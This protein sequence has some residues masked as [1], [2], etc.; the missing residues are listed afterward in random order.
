MNFESRIMCGFGEIHSEIGKKYKKKKERK[1]AEKC[2]Q[3]GQDWA[4]IVSDGFTDSNFT[5]DRGREPLRK[6]CK[7]YI[8]ENLSQ[9]ELSGFLPLLIPILGQLF[10]SFI[11]N[12]VVGKIIENLFNDS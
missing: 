3:L 5:E 6:E 8:K 12:W 11:I 9:E 1:M 10:L 7:E 2:L 4:T